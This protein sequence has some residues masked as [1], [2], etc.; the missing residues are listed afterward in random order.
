MINNQSGGLMRKRIQT[1][2]LRIYK[3]EAARYDFRL[4]LLLIYDIENNETPL[5]FREP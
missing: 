3:S 1:K 5:G 4:F 2:V